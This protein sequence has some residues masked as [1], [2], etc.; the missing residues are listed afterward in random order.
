[1]NEHRM[2]AE[3]AADA[4]ELRER[5]VR[6]LVRSGAIVHPAVEAAFRAV[7]RHRFAPHVPA[8]EVYGAPEAIFTKRT[9]DG[10]VVSS[11]SAPWLHARM[12]EAARL[13]P[14]M[15]VLEIG[16]GG[17]N[18]AL[19]AE[20][21]GPAGVVTSLDI[22]P[23]ITGR[24]RRLLDDAGYQ[25]VQV[26]TGDGALPVPDAPAGG[27]DRIIVTAGS[28]DLPETWLDQLSGS[29][30]LVV[31]LRFRG[32]SRTFA[33]AWRGDQLRS[34]STIVSGFLAMR[35][36]SA[37]AP[38]IV[39]LADEDVRLTVDER[40]PCD[41]SALRAAFSSVGHEV[42]TGVRLTGSEGV[43]P[44]LDVWL[45]G[46]VAP[47]GRLRA[48][49]AAAERGL[50]G[51]VLGTGAA[52]IW[53]DSSLAYL[54]LRSAPEHANQFELGVVAHGPD[55]KDLGLAFADEVIRWNTTAR[56]Q[57]EPE[58]RV[59]RLDDLAPPGVVIE[60]PSV[61]LTIG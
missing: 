59:H 43:L 25:R 3:A 44:R 31:P 48:S 11:V 18:A 5:M 32:L 57:G 47:Y 19:L 26:R 34:D 58:V 42:W 40:Q 28:A 8:A 30:R 14:G 24:A 2:T 56:H 1:M 50:V 41:E 9:D 7:P 45:A 21:V 38:R 60:K 52:A 15:R 17:C 13:A 27:W 61:R 49:R 53:T 36:K 10:R 29:G 39:R 22:D 51:W 35:G 37:D 23:D 16:S 4:G 20:L 46:V 54:A 33:F 55:R 12:L 6:E